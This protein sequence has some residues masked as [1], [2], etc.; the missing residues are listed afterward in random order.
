MPPPSV[1]LLSLATLVVF[2]LMVFQ[3]FWL[4]RNGTLSRSKVLFH[5]IF[6]A[7]LSACLLAELTL[8]VS[9]VSKIKP[10]T[11]DAAVDTMLIIRVSAEMLQY[12]IPL[13]FAVMAGTL[14]TL[15]VEIKIVDDDPNI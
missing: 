5:G 12:I 7:L 14:I 3:A 6:M 4:W 10:R 8:L 2:S 1:F 13:T 11:P 15:A 9:E